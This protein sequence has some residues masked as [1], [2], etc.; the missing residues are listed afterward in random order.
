MGR[1]QSLIIVNNK[2]EC[3]FETLTIKIEKPR[4][5]IIRIVEEDFDKRELELT[6]H[7]LR[8]LNRPNPKTG[9]IHP[10]ERPQS[11]YTQH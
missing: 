2:D 11:K 10:D 3:F 9:K 5:E 7:E 6:D 1:I 8:E 4:V